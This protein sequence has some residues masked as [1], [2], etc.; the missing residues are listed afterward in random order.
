MEKF[1]N[2]KEKFDNSKESSTREMILNE[3]RWQNTLQAFKM[4]AA[5]LNLKACKKFQ[6]EVEVAGL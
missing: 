6:V 4:V 3:E 1:D 2:S 5:S